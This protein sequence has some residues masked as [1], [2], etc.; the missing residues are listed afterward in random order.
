MSEWQNSKNARKA[1]LLIFVSTKSN[2]STFPARASSKWAT[3]TRIANTEFQKP[4]VI[5]WK[6]GRGKEN[7]DEPWQRDGWM[8]RLRPLIWKLTSFVDAALGVAW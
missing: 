1:Y 4:D 8:D 5:F 3:Q 7:S 6:C 2:K